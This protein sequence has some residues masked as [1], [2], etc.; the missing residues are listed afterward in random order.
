MLISSPSQTDGVEWFLRFSFMCKCSKLLS[1]WH[2][3]F[4][5]KWFKPSNWRGEMQYNS[6]SLLGFVSLK[7]SW[8]IPSWLLGCSFW[9]WWDCVCICGPEEAFYCILTS[10]SYERD[11]GW[12][13]RIILQ[14]FSWRCSWCCNLFICCD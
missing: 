9:A 2:C 14:W 7:N 3:K 12:N 8:I 13:D 5:L 1:E 6:L 11:T 10:L 4:S